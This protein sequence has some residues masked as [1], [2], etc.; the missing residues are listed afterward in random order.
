MIVVI[1]EVPPSDL[2]PNIARRRSYHALSDAA[3]PLRASAMVE[4][5]QAAFAV[6]SINGGAIFPKPARLMVRVCVQWPNGRRM[7]D[8]DALGLACKP[9]MDGLTDA[10]I[11]DD[12]GQIAEVCYRQERGAGCVV[13]EV[14][15]A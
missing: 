11:W 5:M 14:M 12:D 3:A 13:V 6:R 8:V 15:G 10:K 2:F 1:G 9:I 4:A 7:P